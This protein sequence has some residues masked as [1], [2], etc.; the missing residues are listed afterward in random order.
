MHNGRPTSHSFHIIT[1]GCKVNQYE[2]EMMREELIA[3]GWAERPDE[4]DVVVVNTCT[5]THRADA[6]ARRAIRRAAREHPGCRIAVTGCAV[7]RDRGFCDGLPG[8]WRVLGNDAKPFI[9]QALA[10]E[11][12]HLSAEARPFGR[13]I[14][15]FSGHTRAFVKVQDGCSAGCTYCI[16]PAVRGRERS[17]PSGE[18]VAE[19][20]RLAGRFHEIV[21]TGIHLGRYEDPDAGIGLAGLASRLLGDTP[22][23]RLRLS[24]IE[25]GEVTD[26]LISLCARSDRL[27]PHFHV[28]LQSG[29]DRVLGRMNRPYTAAEYLALLDR[30]RG[31]LDRPAVSTDVMVGFPGETAA[32]FGRTLAVCEQAQ[33]ARIHVFP[34]SDRPGTA[35]S[36]L[37]DKVHDA[38]VSDRKAQLE[39]RA[40]Q[41][42]LEYKRR[43]VGRTV[44]V[45]VESRCDRTGALSG[46]CPRYLRVRFEGPAEMVGRVRPALI[47]GARPDILLG[48]AEHA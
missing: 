45:L 17:R 48:Q 10:G 41:L 38:D 8:V 22:I 5:V 46:Y 19:V 30:L 1:A 9:A 12:G 11:N 29:S 25:P 43:F 34:Y 36:K 27:C 42:A 28:P 4:P 40:D 32:D 3:A 44:P 37:P 6:K 15:G 26:E 39:E 20:A 24:S 47:T 31:E 2:S 21:L 23:E 35:A 33:F 7:E 18:V 14:S 13:G 16:V